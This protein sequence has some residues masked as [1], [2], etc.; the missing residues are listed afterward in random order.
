MDKLGKIRRRDWK[1]RL[2]IRKTTKFES[3]TSWESEDM[4]LQSCENLQIFVL[5][6][7]GGGGQERGSQH[8]TNVCKISRLWGAVSFLVYFTQFK[9]LFY[10]SVDRFSRTCP[11]QK[12][13]K[14]T[15]KRSI[16]NV[17]TML[18]T[19][20]NSFSPGTCIHVISK[21]PDSPATQRTLN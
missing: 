6:G 4:A 12:L 14:K 20:S 18:T 11:C 2:N 13:R 5:L 3:D 16:R 1:G 15:V 10:S 17:I 7:G 21:A 9:V 19:G 8:L